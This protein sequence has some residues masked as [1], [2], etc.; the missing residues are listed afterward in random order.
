M[1][2]RPSSVGIRS[3]WLVGVG[4]PAGD[5]APR[6]GPAPAA[7][8]GWP[9]RRRCTTS[10]CRPPWAPSRSPW[11]E[12]NTTIVSSA[13][14]EAS[15]RVE[16]PPDGLIDQLVQVVVEPPV[17]EVGGLRRRSSAATASLNCSWH[18]GRPANESA[19][20]G[21][22]GMSGTVSS[23]GLEPEEQLVETA[24]EGDVVRVHERGHRQP[25]PVARRLGQLAEQLDHLLGEHAVAHGAAVGLGARRGAR[26]RSSRRTRTGRAGRP[27][28]R[29][30]P[31][32]GSGRR[33]RRRPSGPRGC[34]G[35]ARS[36]WLT[37]HLP[38]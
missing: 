5:R 25:R 6:R 30:R 15:Q 12:V 26:G 20:D 19:C 29:P 32:R 8:R 38:R 10:A 37:C 18:A 17:G 7:G 1:P 27:C 4:D 35:I 36:A 16:D 11:S 21:A 3:T 24:G 34:P 31:P 14:P 2:A 9:R 22:S 28:G 33:R 13:M 23:G